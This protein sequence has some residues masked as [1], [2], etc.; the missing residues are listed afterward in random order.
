PRGPP[1]LEETLYWATL[2]LD[3]TAPVRGNAAQPPDRMIGNGGDKNIVDAVEYLV[4]RAWAD[5]EGRNR[6]GVVLIADQ[7]VFA[8]RDVQKADARPGGFTVTGGH[9]GLLGAVGHEGPPVLTYIPTRRHTFQS[10]VN[11]S[12]LP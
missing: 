6:V 8:A 4:S 1:R 11:L 5:G 10:E 9:G 2:A 7:R 3:T 12:R